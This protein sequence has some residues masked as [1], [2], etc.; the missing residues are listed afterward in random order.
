MSEGGV[1]ATSSVRGPGRLRVFLEPAVEPA[2]ASVAASVELG[3]FEPAPRAQ[4]LIIPGDSEPTRLRLQAD[5]GPVTLRDLALARFAEPPVPPDPSLISDQAPLPNIIF[6]VVDSLRADHLGVYGYPEDTSP[7]LDRFAERA[8]VFRQASAQ[9]SW[10]RTGV[11]SILTGLDPWQHRV[12]GRLDALPENVHYLPQALRELGY[13]TAGFVTNGNLTAGFGFARGFDTYEHLPETDSDWVHVPSEELH[14]RALSWLDSIAEEDRANPANG[15]RPFF[16]YLHSTDPHYPYRLPLKGAAGTLS[17]EDPASEQHWGSLERIVALQL[18]RA[19]AEP[20]ELEA[21]VE[22]YDREIAYNDQQFGLLL[23][24]LNL[25]GLLD[26]SLLV[27]TADHGEE[28]LDHGGWGHGQTLEIEQL[29]VPLLIKFPGQLRSFEIDNVVSQSDLAPTILAALASL[30][31]GRAQSLLHLM[32]ENPTNWRRASLASLE[33]DGFS[34]DSARWGSFLLIRELPEG[35]RF[36]DLNVDRHGDR[37]EH[38]PAWAQYLSALL[39][40]A[41]AGGD[42]SVTVEPDEEVEKTLRALG[43]I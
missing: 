11:A 43:Y 18:G 35:R 17:D 29:H 40:G 38:F 21:T 2:D 39:D 14:A 12:Q 10:T 26:P 42:A 32:R 20:G 4:D 31:P 16:L 5:G 24:S 1:L 19:E 15:A 22:L 6:Y 36:I 9:S 28:F 30:Q 25:R 37:S 13:R 23:D 3:S 41:S 27:Y 8:A 34:L 7:E 33:L